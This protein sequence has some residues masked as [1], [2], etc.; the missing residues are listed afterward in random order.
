MFVAI[1]NIGKLTAD[2]KVLILGD[3]LELGEESPAEHFAVI[4]KALDT[5]VDE[6]IFIGG[7][8]ESQKSKVKS[9]KITFY[10]TVEDAIEGLKAEPVK[11]STVLIKGSRWNGFGTTGRAVIA[12][13]TDLLPSPRYPCRR[14]SVLLAY[15]SF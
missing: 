7:S 1:E 9:Q 4:N 13:F 10:K 5:D 12:S 8:F 3:M 11:D 6:R 15:P 2:R 14:F